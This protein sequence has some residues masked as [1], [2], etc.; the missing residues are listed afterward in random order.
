MF[1]VN[2]KTVYKNTPSYNAAQHLTGVMYGI[3]SPTVTLFPPYF[4]G[5]MLKLFFYPKLSLP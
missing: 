1:K 5:I 2:V 4:S 3:F